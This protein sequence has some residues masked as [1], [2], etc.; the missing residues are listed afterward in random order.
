MAVRLAGFELRDSIGYA[1]DPVRDKPRP[2]GRG[3]I[4]A[5]SMGAIL[6]VEVLPQADHSERKEMQLRKGDRA[7][8]GS[9][10]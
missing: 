3:R 9:M 5:P 4:G 2:S 7:W 8:E 1:H 6:E 10:E